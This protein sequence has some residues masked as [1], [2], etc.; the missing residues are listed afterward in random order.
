MEKTMR[1]KQIGGVIVPVIVVRPSNRK[2]KKVANCKCATE[3]VKQAEAAK[4]GQAAF[5]EGE[6]E[7]SR[8]FGHTSQS[9]LKS[10]FVRSPNYIDETCYSYASTAIQ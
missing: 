10:R 4:A 1:Q 9:Y 8:T 2:L 6:N 3:G 5:F 7:F